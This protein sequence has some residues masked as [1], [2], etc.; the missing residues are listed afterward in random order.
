[1]IKKFGFRNFG[2]FKD[3]AEISFTYNK[4]TPED[5]AQ[6]QGVGTVL[7]IKGANGSGK[8][9]ILKALVFL[10]CFC[11][12]RMGTRSN[13]HTKESIIDIPLETF[14]DNDDISEFYIEFLINNT[15][16]YYELDLS[17]H[18]IHREELRRKNKKE[19]VCVIRENNK[20]TEC[21]KEFSELKSLNLKADQSIV[22]VISDFNFNSPMEDLKTINLAFIMIQFNVGEGGYQ[23]YDIDDFFHVSEFY[24]KNPEALEF[25]QNI[26]SCI[27]EGVSD[28]VIEETVDKSSGETTFYPMFV[29]HNEDAEFSIGLAHESMGTKSLFLNLHRYWLALV[30]GSLLVLDEF[31]THLHAM[32]LPEII[33]LFTNTEINKYGAQLIITAHNTEIIDN[34]GRYRVILVNKENNESYCYRLDEVNMLRNDRAIAPIYSKGKIGGTPK[35]IQNLTKRLAEKWR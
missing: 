6:G 20:V 28:I 22:S 5:T 32:I 23:S 17:K 27:D 4:N 2:S 19:I 3:G 33:E 30:D 31:D 15:T 25:A 8:T 11:T 29:H 9:N 18:G 24:K 10:H 16:Y 1:M 7:G 14:F 21:L 26:I 12:K 34:L 35:N 13:S